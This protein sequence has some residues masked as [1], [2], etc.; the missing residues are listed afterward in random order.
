M[1]VELVIQKVMKVKLLDIL[2]GEMKAYLKNLQESTFTNGQETVYSTNGNGMKVASFDH[3]KSAMIAG[4]NSR[5]SGDLL[6]LQIGADGETLTA[7]TEYMYTE[8]LTIA[9]NAAATKYVATGTA[10]DEIKFAY[11]LDVNGNRTGVTLTQDALT[12]SGKFAYDSGTKTLTTTG[13]TDG[14][15]ILVNYYPTVVNGMKYGN[16]GGNVSATCKVVADCIFKDVCTD[17]L[18]Y[19]Q[20]ISDKGHV[21]GA[22]EWSLSEGGSPSLHNF[23]VELLG[24]CE[25]EKLWDYIIIG[26]DGL[27]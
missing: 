24:N 7:N 16:L 14:T 3:T 25:D 23:S 4:A 18:V 11:V 26:E 19:G 6:A 21:S 15:K 12:A 5:I 10:D 13:L 20:L 27:Q 22:F 8:I 17:Q 1:N 9:S 2:T